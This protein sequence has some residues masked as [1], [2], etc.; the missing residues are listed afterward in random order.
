MD[1]KKCSTEADGRAL[2]VEML[3]EASDIGLNDL[4]FREYER[5]GRPQDQLV[6]RYL[7]QLRDADR[8]VAIG[9]SSVLSDFLGS[10]EG[11]VDLEIYEQAFH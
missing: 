1:D 9:F 6:L 2:A 5:D 4:A 11:S 3:R 10:C 7:D 8:R